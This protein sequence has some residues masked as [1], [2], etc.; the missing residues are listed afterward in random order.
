[1]NQLRMLL[2]FLLAGASCVLSCSTAPDVVP[3]PSTGVQP[4]RAL[5]GVPA[6]PGAEGFGSDTP[7]G[8]GGTVLIVTSLED[9][10]PH[11]DAPIPGT[12]RW[13][14]D[15]PR[16]RI[17]VFRVTG[18]IHLTSPLVIGDLEDPQTANSCSYLTLAGQSAPGGGITI[19]DQPLV[20][21]GGVHDVIIRHLRVRNTPIDG[22][23][24]TRGSRRVVIDHCSVSWATDENF[25]FYGSNTD[26][27]IQ[28]CIVAECL[29][30]GGHR[31]G[32]HSMGFLISRGADRVSLHH[33][34]I[35]ANDARNPQFV[36]NNSILRD[37]ARFGNPFPVFD[38]RN[39]IIY[40]CRTWTRLNHGAQTNI[41]RNL[42]VK[43]PDG[44]EMPVFFFFN[45]QD[46][47]RAWLEGNEF[48]WK[49]SPVDQW[50]M[51][52]V[53]CEYLTPEQLERTQ[54]DVSLCRADAPFPAP[55]TTQVPVSQLPQ[56]V[57]PTVGALPHDPV[58]SRLIAEFHHGTGSSG[59]PNRT[60]DTPVPS[61]DPGEPPPDSDGDGIPDTWEQQHSL[62]P[63]D[64][65][66]AV[67]TSARSPYTCIE[68]YLNQRAD[69]LA[70]EPQNRSASAR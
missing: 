52:S 39:N 11:R 12:L 22:I 46:N 19:A 13:A 38:M 1:M 42:Y 40:N 4:T 60:H 65:S 48:S 20:I 9:Y 67:L 10:H 18:I 5:G 54:Q 56:H 37:R 35:A 7:G 23:S 62:D 17:V 26:V 58:D 16:P 55:P 27:S 3:V 36:G 63:H 43:G 34:F 68:E 47:T 66:D 33:N 45:D 14:L 24:F 44:H 70:A 50:S 51:V 25:G 32:T 29:R 30:H 15:Q 53:G 59:A 31:K 41:I 61:P 6:F 21:G 28:N 64:P 49:E 69:Q 8:R 2:P 57:I